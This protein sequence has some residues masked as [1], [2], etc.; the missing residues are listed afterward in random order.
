MSSQDKAATNIKLIVWKKSKEK[1]KYK[2]YINNC[3]I[4]NDLRLDEYIKENLIDYGKSYD[5]I[6]V[7]KEHMIIPKDNEKIILE[8]INDNTIVEIHMKIDDNLYLLST[9]CHKIRNPINNIL[10][11]LT[12]INETGLTKEQ[13]KYFNVINNSSCDIVGVAND[14]LDIISL[15]KDEITLKFE[16]TD[17]KKLLKNVG[18]MNSNDINSKNIGF[19]MNINR[20]VPPV[21]LIDSQ[22]VTQIMCSLLNNA[23]KHT[24]D[25]HISIDVMLF[26]KND[27]SD[28][29]FTYVDMKG[30]TYNILFK[31][32]DT[33]TGMSDSS[34]MF[35]E[36][37]LGISKLAIGEHYK[38]GGFG[39]LISK[40]LC[41]LMGG[42]IWFKTEKDIGTVFYFNIICD[43]LTIN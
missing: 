2:C 36:K 3:D 32:R 6:V 9:I 27:T 35:A 30:Q 16:N 40:Y 34:K 26:D 11:A 41:N 33:G 37:I 42:N 20:N 13:K 31:I 23:I 14:I 4:K 17:I 15:S 18:E 1:D 21:V 22:R 7:K 24:P 12:L 5:D 29:P 8:Y 38:Y 43:G 25:G 28:C 39:L 10:G 19:K